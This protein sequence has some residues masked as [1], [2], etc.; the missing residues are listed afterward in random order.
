[1]DDHLAKPINLRALEQVLSR[2]L[3]ER[4]NVPLSGA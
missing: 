1:M 4:P 2:V 3:A